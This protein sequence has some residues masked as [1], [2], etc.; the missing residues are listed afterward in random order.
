VLK[1]PDYLAD[2]R[3]QKLETDGM[4]GEDIAKLIDRIYASPAPVIARA[5][6]ALEDGK[7]VTTK[8]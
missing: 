2:A 7:K 1:D 3:K 6:A 8:R 5:R 4:R